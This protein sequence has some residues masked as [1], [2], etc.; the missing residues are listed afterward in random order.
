MVSQIIAG[1]SYLEILQ[2]QFWCCFG[3]HLL[4]CA[5]AGNVSEAQK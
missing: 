4:P 3:T 1:L 2:F 5:E